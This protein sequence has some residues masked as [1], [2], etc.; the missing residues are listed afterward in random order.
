MR[1]AHEL[2]R[3]NPPRQVELHFVEDD[4]E[5]V[6]RLQQ[7]VAE[8]GQGIPI[9]VTDGDISA[10]LPALLPMLLQLMTN[11]ATR[12]ALNHRETHCRQHHGLRID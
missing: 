2:A 5:T 7:V 10:H 12:C 3:L 9:T 1:K 11:I 8:E 4:E 6:T